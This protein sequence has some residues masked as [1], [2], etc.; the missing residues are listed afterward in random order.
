MKAILAGALAWAVVAGCV[1][2]VYWTAG[3]DFD[4]GPALGAAT[5]FAIGFSLVAAMFA[6]FFARGDL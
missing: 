2:L 3:G 5:Y 4:R 1:F 6:A